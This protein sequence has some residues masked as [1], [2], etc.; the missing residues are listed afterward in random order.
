MLVAKSSLELTIRTQA[1]WIQELLDPK[2]LPKALIEKCGYP[3]I[4]DPGSKDPEMSVAAYGLGL[5][6]WSYRGRKVV[7]HGGG[8]PGQLTFL[9]RAVDGEF[10]LMV[11]ANDNDVGN[12]LVGSI[13]NRMLDDLLGLEH[14][15]WETRY[16]EKWVDR[17]K[18]KDDEA[19]EKDSG[20][21]TSHTASLAGLYSCPYY[22]DLDLRELSTAGASSGVDDG[23]FKAIRL[24]LEGVGAKAPYYISPL[25]K[26]FTSHIVFSPINGRK[27][28][29]TLIQLLP[30]LNEKR[31][32]TGESL[33][34]VNGTGTAYLDDK[35]IGMF[36]NFYGAGGSV[37][38][39]QAEEKMGHVDDECEVW[40][41]KV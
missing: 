8:I 31:E 19:S 32:K 14:V 27:L 16:F 17:N 37:E 39:K 25:P 4:S 33:F 9:I 12:E 20:A 35:G 41:E 22:G 13:T 18:P 10:G 30:A 7:S 24:A 3:Y 6:S 40:F 28:K 29:W 36:G 23:Q 34:R 11:A 5:R 2:V 1:K 26:I 38:I 21:S 15:D